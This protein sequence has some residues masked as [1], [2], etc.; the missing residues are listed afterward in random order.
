MQ[1]FPLAGK[2]PASEGP[3]NAEDDQEGRL[4][5]QDLRRL[6]AAVRVAQKVGTRLGAG[7]V[8]LGPLPVGEKLSLA[9]C[10][11]LREY[12]SEF[13]FGEGAANPDRADQIGG[14]SAHPELEGLHLVARD[15]SL[16]LG[17]VPRKVAL[18]LLPTASRLLD[19]RPELS[20]AIDR[21]GHLAIVDLRI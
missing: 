9:R 18:Q 2:R 13:A 8:L 19:R 7:Q 12:P 5:D 14:R 10:A 17:S 20:L 15:L 3:A 21:S 11:S 6:R 1:S 16:D 4:A